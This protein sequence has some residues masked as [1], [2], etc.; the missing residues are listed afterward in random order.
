MA[1]RALFGILSKTQHLQL[2]V[3]VQCQLFTSTILPI[4]LYACE[5]WGFEDLNQIEIFQRNFIRNLLK[6]KSYTSSC[7][8]Y[9]ES[10]LMELSCTIKVR[11][12][13]FWYKI[14]TGNNH[15]LSYLMYRLIKKMHDDTNNEYR[16]KWITFIESTINDLGL[17]N[18]WL[19]EGDGFSLD[20]IKRCIK[21]RISDVYQQNWYTSVTGNVHC[22]FY[23]M[24][25]DQIGLR[26]CHPLLSFK[27]RTSLVRF[28]CRNHLLPV[29]RNR[30]YNVNR[31]D[32]MCTYCADNVLGDEFHYFFTCPIFRENRMKFL[33]KQIFQNP[34]VITLRSFFN[35]NNIN[36]LRKVARFSQSIIDHFENL[37]TINSGVDLQPFTVNIGNTTS[38]GRRVARP[39]RFDDYI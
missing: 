19:Y 24:L 14:V 38:S 7:L 22:H 23:R 26:W 9:G 13:S 28:R 11:M 15:K 2:S 33:G 16:S 18:I 12:I 10:G 29:T 17:R 20:Y 35:S 27:D 30:F 21:L 32:L 39:A 6:L 36:L 8:L 34:S 5:I 1:R 3:D 37:I 4:I 31:S 25:K